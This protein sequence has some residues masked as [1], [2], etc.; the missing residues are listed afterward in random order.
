MAGL[1]IRLLGGFDVR[2]DEAALSGFESQKARALLAY[3]ACQPEQ[4]QDRAHLAALLWPGEEAT[5]ARQNL[6]QAAYNLRRS[7]G[8]PAKN[9]PEYLL[10]SHQ[11]LQLNPL[12]DIWLDVVAF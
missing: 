3:L 5:T 4:P 11:I 1:E 9:K 10:S 7:F 2:R 12:A 6:R 8:A